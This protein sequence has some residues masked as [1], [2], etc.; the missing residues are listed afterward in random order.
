M[1]RLLS[2]LVEILGLNLELVQ[3]AREKVGNGNLCER[4]SDVVDERVF[5]GAAAV[6]ESV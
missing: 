5:F 2:K 6:A 1:V 3:A 4:G